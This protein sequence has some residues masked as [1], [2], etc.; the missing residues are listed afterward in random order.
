MLTASSNSMARD[1]V[2]GT[3]LAGTKLITRSPA[4]AWTAVAAPGL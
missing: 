1:G 2:N 4:A 3:V